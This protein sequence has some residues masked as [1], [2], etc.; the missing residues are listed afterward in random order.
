MGMLNV[1]QIQFEDGGGD[2]LDQRIAIINCSKEYT[3][4]NLNAKAFQ[5]NF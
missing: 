1:Q 2:D 3:N 5:F 4:F